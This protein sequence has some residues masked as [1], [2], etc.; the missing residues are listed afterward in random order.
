M[1]LFN[2]TYRVT[3]PTQ[4]HWLIP[5]LWAS[6]C[7]ACTSVSPSCGTA[8]FCS[9]SVFLAFLPSSRPPY[10]PGTQHRA[11]LCR[12]CSGRLLLKLISSPG[13]SSPTS[14][15]SN[16]HIYILNPGLSWPPDSHVQLD[17]NVTQCQQS[18][19][20]ISDFACPSWPLHRSPP[21]ACPSPRVS[22]SPHGTIMLRKVN[23]P[24]VMLDSAL[25]AMPPIQS[26][27]KSCGS[28]FKTDLASISSF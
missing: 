15:I 23:I 20:R 28:T 14:P 18:L 6:L 19:T 13:I 10:P 3:P 24:G 2:V 22:A 16:F 8:M 26:I 11:K 21:Q 7:L 5:L 1:I 9:R 17:S 25:S 12:G 4:G 27:N